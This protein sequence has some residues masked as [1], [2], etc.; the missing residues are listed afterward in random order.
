MLLLLLLPP[1]HVHVLRERGEAFAASVT[2]HLALVREALVG[3]A[4]ISSRCTARD[5]VPGVS[6]TTVG[7]WAE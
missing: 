7:A 3:A 4:Q 5:M 2:G 1:L 6:R